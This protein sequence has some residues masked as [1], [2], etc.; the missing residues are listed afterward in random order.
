[1]RNR[2]FRLLPLGLIL[3]P[4]ISKS[5]VPEQ[6]RDIAVFNQRDFPSYN[7]SGLL[8]PDHIVNRLNKLGIKA[9]SLNAT[10]I[11]NGALRDKKFIALV[12]PYGNTFPKED[13]NAIRDFHSHGGSLIL[14]GVPFT[15]PVSYQSGHGW[16]DQGNETDIALFGANGVGVG[17]FGS[18]SA[19]KLTIP[20]RDP[21]GLR[22]I[23][24]KRNPGTNVQTLD[25][26]SLP[27]EDTVTPFLEE[28]G[29]PVAAAIY[30]NDKQ[31]HGAIDIWTDHPDTGD[32][33]AWDTEQ[34]ILR[35][36]VYLL[37]QKGLLSLNKVKSDYAKISKIPTPQIY[38]NV[39]LPSVARPYPTFQPKMNPPARHLYVADVSKLSPSQKILLLTL[40]GLVN[41]SKPRIY[42]IFD[43]YD[44]FWLKQMQKRGQTGSDILV[45]KPMSLVNTF[46]FAFK[47]AVI[48]DPKIYDSPDV[49]VDAAAAYN[50]LVATPKLASSLHIPV[51]MD[52]RGKFH[53]D[54]NAFRYIRKKLMPHLNTYLSLC[55]DPAILDTG[56]IDQI[57]AAKGITWWVTGSAAESFPGADMAAELQQAKKMLAAMPLDSVVHGFYWRGN[58]IGL[59]EGPGVS[60]ASQFGK[61]TTVSDYV[62][63]FSVLSGVQLKSIKQKYHPVPPKYDPSKVYLA[64]TFSDGDNLCTW[65]GYFLNYF[66]NPLHGTIP[67]GWGMGPSL[68]DCAPTE[69]QWYYDHATPDDEFI[70]DVSGVGYI[71]PPDWATALKHKNQA[72]RS[73]YNWTDLYMHRMD[74]KT[75]R[76]MGV[77]APSIAKVASVMPD[78]SFL[79]PDYG[80]Q[81]ETSYKQ[82]TY[83]L[84]SGQEIFRAGTG[85][86]SGQQLANDVRARV[87]DIRPAFLNVFVMNWSTSLSDLRDM[88][89][90]LGPNYVAVTPSQLAELYRESRTP[91]GVY[92]ASDT[93]TK[94]VSDP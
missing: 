90:I 5:V 68:I 59:D 81:G 9:V 87:G 42:F 51:K 44:T 94:V 36:C 46:R 50:L 22:E 93:G 28:G 53:N 6:A 58:G 71:Y 39:V 88:L 35:S 13:I 76:L 83:T 45:K 73:F 43:K 20:K 18:G 17:G 70:S 75:L 47:G 30:H 54:A 84:P 74:M 80:Y 92:N 31:F 55:L 77:D 62:T 4:A 29:Q 3:I 1:M 8:Q 40:Q 52:L 48:P 25:V 23:Y 69:V 32:Y 57:V 21:L 63:N 49:A 10:Q 15:H 60:L 2:N 67:I 16:V 86:G 14:T 41:R 33:D 72:F 79:M 66:R 64:I 61:I 91:K 37:N 7:V 82:L 34:F 65:R 89:K 24:A 78:V 38:K 19:A 11:L 26:S 85:G 12:L 56:A 27:A